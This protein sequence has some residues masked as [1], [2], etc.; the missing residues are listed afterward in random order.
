MLYPIMPVFLKSIGFSVMLIG[1][2]EGLAEATAGLSKGYFGKL[3]DE[4]RRRLPF[5]QFGYTLSAI[6]KPLM[7]VT[8]YPLWIF[9]ARTLDRLGKGIR[10]AARDAILSAEATPETKARVFGFHRALDTAGA[11]IGPS[12]AL[13]FLYFYPGQYK[14]LFLVAFLPGIASALL[15]LVLKE[16]KL[17]QASSLEEDDAATRAYRPLQETI[18]EKKSVPFFSFL[19]YWKDAPPSYR[20]IAGGLLVF[21]LINSSDIFLLLKAKEAGLTDLQVIGVYIFYNL[22]YAAFA[23]PA[24]MLADR[25]GLRNTLIVGLFIF[26]SVYLGMALH[27]SVVWIGFLFLLYGVYAACTEG[28]TKAWLTN[29]SDKKDTATAIGTYTALQSICTLIASTAAGV[30]WYSLGD[31]TLFI[32]TGLMAFL[33]ACYFVVVK[34]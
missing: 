22:V 17:G 14:T 27:G 29:I 8:V 34:V 28:I 12:I 26:A 18:L 15:T 13:L 4:R 1:L 16:P 19:R 3:S 5:V 30:I 11:F 21:T 32:F 23:Y 24:G 6:S 9:F 33:V 7:A 25:W 31:A 20:K 10:T 2:L